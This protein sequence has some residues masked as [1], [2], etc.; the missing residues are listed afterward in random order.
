M[1]KHLILPF[2][3]SAMLLGGCVYEPIHQ[4]NRL[5]IGSIMQIQEGDTKFS[6]EQALGTPSLDH[7]MQENRVVYFEQFED[8]ESGDMIK[9]GVE[10]TYDDALRVK[11]IRRFGFENEE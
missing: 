10:I 5:K 8:E 6:V 3:L 4:G 7:V 1:I 9:R 2:A 11:E